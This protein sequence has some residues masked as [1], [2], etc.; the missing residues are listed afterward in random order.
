MGDSSRG[1]DAHGGVA[2]SSGLGVKRALEHV[3]GAIDDRY[4]ISV[5]NDSELKDAQ[6]LGNPHVKEEPSD[7]LH[8]SS[9]D[10]RG[11][12]P[13]AES[14]EVETFR[15]SEAFGD[16]SRQRPLGSRR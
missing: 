15:D 13:S 4:S 9:E 3:E 14:P 12:T 7:G 1:G 8:V 11:V 5:M 6:F 2:K 10:A 16:V